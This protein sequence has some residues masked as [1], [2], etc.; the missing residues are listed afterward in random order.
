[1]VGALNSELE[2]LAPC[3]TENNENVFSKYPARLP[4]EAFPAAPEKD[5]YRFARGHLAAFQPV[6]QGNKRLGTL[7]LKSDMGAMYERFRLYGGI[8]LLV[9]AVSFLVA[10]LLSRPPQSQICKPI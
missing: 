8:V 9:I 4:A 6:A 2:I 5:G 3:L 7:Y 10:F 1:M